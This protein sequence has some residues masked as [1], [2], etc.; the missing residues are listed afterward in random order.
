ML[1]TLL[2]AAHV[3]TFDLVDNRVFVDAKIN[4]RGPYHLLL[5]TG[6]GS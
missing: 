2:L 3:F 4:G 6:A 5:D 1:A